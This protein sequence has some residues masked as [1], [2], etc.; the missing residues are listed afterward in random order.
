M[1]RATFR[2][3][4]LAIL[5]ASGSAGYWY[6][7]NPQSLPQQ[8]RKLEED[9]RELQQI[10]RR[11]SDERR[12]AEMIVTEQRPAAEG[13][14]LETTLLFVEQARDGTPLPAKS[15]T[16]RGDEVWLAG[17][18]IRFE[19]GFVEKGDALRG[20]GIMLFTKLFGQNQTP[21]QGVEVDETGK[22]PDIYRGDPKEVAR[23]SA[24]ERELWGDFWRLVDDKQY[25]AE[26]GVAAAGGKAV[27]F[28]AQPDRLYRVT[29]DASGNPSVEW[30]PIKPIYREAMRK[31]AGPGVVTQ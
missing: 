10:V 6:F 20:R 9:K 23:V 19:Q 15:F 26:K 7:H 28:R 13:S 8:V 2:L 18:S 12:V 14:G 29:L 27:Y 11:L 16:V 4:V 3:V 24:F 25:R 21:A 17:L 1:L 30:E 5:V 22:I 31:A